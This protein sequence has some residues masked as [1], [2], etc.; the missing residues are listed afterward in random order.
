MNKNNFYRC[1]G[2]KLKELR[3]DKN[4][5]QNEVCEKFRLSRSSLANIEAGRHR[6]SIYTL[7]QLLCI[8]KENEF[9]DDKKIKEDML[10]NLHK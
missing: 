3:E 6:L 5:S 9:M 10:N 1:L 4:I 8:L 7:Y 2:S